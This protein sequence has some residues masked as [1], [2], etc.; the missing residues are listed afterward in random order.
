MDQDEKYWAKEW[1]KQ[2]ARLADA[3]ETIAG[4]LAY[5]AGSVKDLRA[6]AAAQG[7]KEAL[8]TRASAVRQMQR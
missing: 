1:V 5:L 7:D 2:S 8:S 3:L 4:D 6:E